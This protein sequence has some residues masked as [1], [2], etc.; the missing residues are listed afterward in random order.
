MR[1][2]SPAPLVGRRGFD[3]DA[4]VCDADLVDIERYAAGWRRRFEEEE[5]ALAARADAARGAAR[6]AAS[7]L[8]E[9][10]GVQEVWL[11]GSLATGGPR[12]AG[13]DIDLAVTGLDAARYFTAL[14]RIGELT[15]VPA[16]L[17]TLESCSPALRERIREEGIR[18][19]VA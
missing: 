15:D 1:A 7:L 17:V 11:F 14:S 2:A 10:F 8:V 3:I 18:L 19:H 5:A 4:S 6:R 16:D 12:H 9:A 13:F